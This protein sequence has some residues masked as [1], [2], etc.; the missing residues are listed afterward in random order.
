MGLRKR[1][2]KMS[3][4]RSAIAENELRNTLSDFH[5]GACETEP[6]KHW[7]G[8]NTS[9]EY[10]RVDVRKGARHISRT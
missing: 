10:G 3:D 4:F 6:N 7:G 8:G 9:S 5:F 1:F 2:P